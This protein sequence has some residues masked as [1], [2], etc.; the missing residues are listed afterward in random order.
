M[1]PDGRTVVVGTSNMR[2][3]AGAYSRMAVLRFLVDGGLDPTFGDG[4]RVLLDE[5]RGA[6]AQGVAVQPDGRI[7]VVGGV[8]D[9]SGQ[10]LGNMAVTRLDPNGQRDPTFNGGTVL[11]LDDRWT[12]GNA[13]HVTLQPDGKLVV[14]GAASPTGGDSTRRVSAVAVLRLTPS[15]ALDGSFGDRGLV[16]TDLDG[17]EQYDGGVFAAVRPDGRIVVAGTTSSASF[18]DVPPVHQIMVQYT[19]TGALD[20]TFG[21]GGIVVNPVLGTATSAVMK[22]NGTVVTTGDVQYGRSERGNT[23]SVVLTAYRP[24]GALDTRFG[25]GGSTVTHAPNVEE[26]GVTVSGANGYGEAIALDARGRLVVAGL[27]S[28]WPSSDLALLRYNGAGGLDASFG[29]AGWA[30]TDVAD[31]DEFAAVG[32]LPNGGVVAAGQSTN[33]DTQSI[34]FAVLPATAETATAHGWGWNKLAQLGDGATVDRLA[35]ISVAGPTGASLLAG[36]AGHSLALDDGGGVSA[37]GWNGVGQIGDGTTTD[38][39]RPVRVAGLTDVSAVASGY[40]HS[41]AVA[42]GT[43]KAWGWNGYGQLGDGTVVDRHRPVAVV[44]L[45]G[46]IGVSAGAFHSLAVRN[47]G[48]VWAWGWNGVGQLGDGTTTDRR[49]PVV[50]PGLKDVIAVSAGAYHS[51]ALKVDGSVWAWGWNPF[52]Q[53]G[54]GSTTDRHT[55]VK[56]I[57][58]GVATIAAGG[59][60]S[61]ALKEDGAVL[62]WGWNG[63]GELGDGSIV[64][65]TSPV[66]VAGL[67]PAKAIA[68]GLLH[69]VAIRT[70]GRV[71]SWGWNG[72]GQLGDGTAVDSH[73]P[74][75]TGGTGPVEAIA[76]GAY[77]SLGAGP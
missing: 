54:E 10:A 41:L 47:D 67:P 64:G 32:V 66:R 31:Y 3:E 11:A 40:Y 30:K 63:Y 19:A 68:A 38:R 70:D 33:A 58:S 53:L 16:R 45:T 43:I 6:W 24:D 22:P 50:V 37:W 4:G 71:E 25:A 21:N 12:Y 60:H 49:Q 59:L 39:Q 73:Q 42:G 35:P 17:W 26:A 1:Q 36:G 23:R 18:S 77:H 74:V 9:S 5:G 69:S 34:V 28:G 46:V 75:L 72:V 62:A 65:R 76:A 8:E 7:V 55:P 52:G 15:G 14:T 13:R 44:G 48:T 2:R 61:L 56:V 27:A 51:L 29:R 57:A 20:P